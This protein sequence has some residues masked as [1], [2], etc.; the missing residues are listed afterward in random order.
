MPFMDYE[1]DL[2][3]D[4]YVYCIN[5]KLTAI[6]MWFSNAYTFLRNNNKKW[7]YMEIQFFYF[8]EIEN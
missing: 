2:G 5:A 3:S 8:Y 6:S 1:S 4:V 7:M